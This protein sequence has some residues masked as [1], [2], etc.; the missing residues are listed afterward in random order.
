MLA[1]RYELGEVLGRGGMA[2]VRVAHDRVLGRQVAIKLLRPDLAH[3]PEVLSRFRREARAVAALNHPSVV[4]VHDVGEDALGPHD[5]PVPFLVME[6]VR[7]ATV[8][9]LLAQHRPAQHEP[10]EDRSAEHGLARHRPADDEPTVAADREPAPAE[11]SRVAGE[12]DEAT[13]ALDPREQPGVGV[14]MAV[15]I[16][17]GVLTALA[18]SHRA[19]IVH[20][21]IKPANVMLTPDGRVKVMDFGI[22][23]ALADAS[24]TATHT[25]AVL[26][27]AQYLSPEQARGRPVDARADLYSTGCLLYE[28]LT[29][30]P[31]FLG[32]SAVSLAYQHVSETPDPPS[33]HHPGLPLGMDRVVLRAMAKEPEDRYPDADAFRR[34]LEDAARGL[35]AAP[36]AA[37]AA[38]STTAMPTAPLA[39][40][41][42]AEDGDDDEPV[43]GQRGRR[44]VVVL[45]ALVALALVALAAVLV[46]QLVGSDDG[47]AALRTVPDVVGSTREAARAAVEQQGLVY[48]QTSA[49]SDDVAEGRVAEQDPEGSTSAPEGSTVAVVVSTG[50]G[51][52]AVP[53]LAGLTEAQALRALQSADLQLGEVERVSDERV[54]EGSVV[55]TDPSEGSTAEPGSAVDLVLSD[56]TVEIDDYT[57]LPQLA[58][59]EAL[60]A[61]G[62][63]SRLEFSE[64]EEEENT[65]VDQRPGEGAV[66]QG[67]TV[68][69]VVATPPPPPPPPP[70]TPTATP[71]PTTTPTSPPTE[72][73]STPQ[74]TPTT[75]PTTPGP[76][77]TE[78]PTAAPTTTG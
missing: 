27:T 49:P 59:R 28:L 45:T 67:S 15:T 21:D 18:Y 30:R 7:G 47:D 14:E 61:L 73:T 53:D 23:R 48:A 39:P 16:T 75:A 55:R 76:T 20:R 36:P 63:Q 11:G 70:P 60:A 5:P 69:L 37:V 41:P 58:A 74:P 19:G 26:G 62:L 10:A 65:V 29:G 66:P 12:A 44:A 2:S 34:D 22:A 31:P 9:D 78:T 24:A 54:P 68:V 38:A 6:L 51:L 57:G 43:T 46:P 40:V 13:R 42:L 56:G 52:V 17:T 25:S 64:S 3:D 72:P 50:P 8:R 33:T 4:G 71:E 1:G 35:D 77:A 32:E